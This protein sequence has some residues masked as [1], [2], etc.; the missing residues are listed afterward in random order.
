M[1]RPV[2]IIELPGFQAPHESQ[3]AERAHAEGNGNK[4]DQNRHQR[5]SLKALRVTRMDEPDMAMAATSG[6]TKPNTASGTAI[7]L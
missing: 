3:K 4:P 7:M 5:D 2:Q 6:V 1:G